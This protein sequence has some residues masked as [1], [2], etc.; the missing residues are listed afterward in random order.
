MQKPVQPNKP[1]RSRR[2]RQRKSCHLLNLPGE[3]RNHIYE[4]VVVE[5]DR[6]EITSEGPGEPPLLRTCRQ[7]RREAGS[8]YYRSNIFAFCLEAYNGAD[9]VP[10][11]RQ[12]DKFIWTLRE[13]AV[14]FTWPLNTDRNWDNLVRSSPPLVAGSSRGVLTDF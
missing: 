6:V 9:F 4:M 7:I 14:M 5:P 2:P 11:I 13:G 8:L 1:K 3:L 10:F 12:A